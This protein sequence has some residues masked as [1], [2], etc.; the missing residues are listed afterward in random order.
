VSRIGISRRRDEQG[1]AMITAILATFVVMALSLTSIQLSRHNTDASS[2]DRARVQAVHAAEAGLDLTLSAMQSTSSASLPCTQSGTLAGTPARAWS[3]SVSY[4]ATSDGTGAALAC[5][6]ASNAIAGSA[7]VTSIGTVGAGLRSARRTMETLVKLTPIYGGFDKAIFSNQTPSL[8]NN[9][10]VHG[11]TGNDANFYTNGSFNCS[12]GFSL[13]GSLFVQ[14]S[15]TLS[16]ACSIVVDAWANNA[17]TFQNNTVIG[18]DAKSSTSS[19]TMANSAKVANN[20]TAGT[21]C[22]GCSG[23]VGGSIV[24]NAPQAAPPLSDFPQIPWDQSDWTANGWT[25]QSFSGT[26]ACTDAKAFLGS[27]SPLVD[28]V[29]RVNR[30]CTLELANNTDVTLRAN[31][32]VVTDGILTTSNH[33]TFQSSV[34]GVARNLFFMVPYGTSCT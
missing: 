18:H 15:I 21:T 11:N 28:A 16:N 2:Y 22:A 5:P 23:R 34:A 20:A 27:Q 4:Y 13:Q 33:V 14:G 7:L 25:V 6:V 31:L 8:A 26:N 1:I 3:A 24:T 10:D 29:I 12:N 32:A 30:A 19:I 9:L 17:M